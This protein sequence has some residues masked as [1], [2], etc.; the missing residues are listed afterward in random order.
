MIMPQSLFYITP[1][2]ALLCTFVAEV[3]YTQLHTQ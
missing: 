2:T 3:V 1:Y